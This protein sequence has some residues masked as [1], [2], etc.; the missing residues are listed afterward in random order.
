MALIDAFL[1]IHKKTKFPNLGLTTF[2]GEKGFAVTEDGFLR[3]DGDI[4]ETKTEQVLE[5]TGLKEFYSKKENKPPNKKPP[6][7]DSYDDYD[8][9]YDVD[10]P[11][12]WTGN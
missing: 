8:D 3:P 11:S 10:P 2:V 12:D 4:F 9:G 5:L 7:E 1:R 6:K